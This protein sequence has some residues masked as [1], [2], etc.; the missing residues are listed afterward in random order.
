DDFGLLAIAVTA[1]GFLLSV[2]DF[3]M[4]PA[5]VQGKQIQADQYDA[6]WTVEVS[7]ALAI[8][9]GTVVTAPLIAHLFAEPRATA[10]IQ[11]LAIRPFLDA[12]SSIRVAE[13]NRDL[14]FRPTTLMGL[15]EA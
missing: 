5:L 6:A 15:A 10:I 2:T 4:I 1:V 11:V 7:R 14:R 13:M 9:L 3:G 12:L 8:S